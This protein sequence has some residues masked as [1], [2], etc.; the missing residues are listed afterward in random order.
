MNR[1]SDDLDAAGVLARSEA[2]VRRRRAAAVEDL[3]L[4]LVWADLH[5]EDV[6]LTV[7]GGEKLVGLGGE[8]TPRVRD[9]ALAELSIA[10]QTHVHAT[11]TATA[12]ALDLRHRL[13]RL[14]AE[15]RALA[16]EAW[17]ARKVASMTRALTPHAAGS[18]DAKVSAAVHESPGRLLRIAE[19]A[20][21]E[22]DQEDHRTKR[23]EAA[24][25]RGVWLC[26][27]APGH[28]LDPTTAGLRT[29]VARVDAADAIWFDATI[30]RLADEVAAE[31][32]SAIDVVETSRDELRAEA[33]GR[34]AR[35]AEPGPGEE[36]V[37]FVHLSP[38]SELAR[39]EQHGPVLTEW[40]ADLV[41]HTRI[42]V[43]PVVDLNEG[44]SVNAY[45][46]P[47]AVK[48]RSRLRSPGDRFPHATTLGGRIDHDHVIPYDRHGPPGQT[49]DHNTNP[50]GRFGHRAKTHLGYRV[51]QLSPGTHIWTTPHGLHRLVTPHGTQVLTEP[52]VQLALLI[53]GDPQAA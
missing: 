44:S 28:E 19:A 12:D 25:G 30:D 16:C 8:G 51:R 48:L 22:A 27:T 41:G 10:R 36:A 53:A 3:E 6:A 1:P 15:T 35:S 47:A 14:W 52:E 17:V 20:I 40:L 9:L 49:G 4:V 46:H 34:L 37:V 11:R 39:V 5:G 45:E 2:V 43:M 7:P 33:F 29:I 38:D 31:R 50:L 32:A 13:P 26:R 23:A 24:R 21:L 42:R 18:V